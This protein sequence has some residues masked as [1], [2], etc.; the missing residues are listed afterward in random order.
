V[1]VVAG[2]LWLRSSSVG[3]T[4]SPTPS[5]SPTYSAPAIYTRS[6]PDAAELDSEWVGLTGVALGDGFVLAEE[7]GNAIWVGDG[8]TWERVRSS[9]LDGMWIW[10]LARYDGGVMALGWKNPITTEPLD[11]S[12]LEVATS[13]DGRSWTRVAHASLALFDN[14]S[15]SRATNGPAGV[16]VEGHDTL[17]GGAFVFRTW[18]SVDG[19][20]WQAGQALPDDFEWIGDLAADDTAYVAVGAPAL[21]WRSEDG[22]TWSP[23]EGTSLPV[24]GEGTVSL[25]PLPGGGFVGFESSCSPYEYWLS[26][27]GLTWHPRDWMA[28]PLP[29]SNAFGGD[30][31]RVVA[32]GSDGVWQ[33]LDGE[34]W[35]HIAKVA[36][37]PLGARSVRVVV[38]KSGVA[39]LVGGSS[40]VFVDAPPPDSP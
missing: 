32:V 35:S 22:L 28:V 5:S 34:T 10:D 39:A 18:S 40:V 21:G 1:A 25:L 12:G 37:E 9:A 27:D 6:L 16:V 8:Q 24:W 13:R 17:P 20:S 38:G 14:A 15:V 36:I 31:S 7:N 33:T 4:P 11:L 19:V 29:C 2:S 26:H 23:L 30:G 3:T